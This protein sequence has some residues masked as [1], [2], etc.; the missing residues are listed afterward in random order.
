MRPADDREP[1]PEPRPIAPSVARATLVLL[2]ALNF[3]NYVDRYVL[4]AVLEKIKLDPAFAGV[5]DAQLG[6][7][8]TAF[9][10]VYMIASP[11]SGALGHRV[12][13]KYLVTV[14]VGLWSL[15]TVAS[16]L[17]RNYHE[18]ALAR[19]M[20][21][22]G[23]AGYAT[24]APA[25]L[26]DLY[27]RDRRARVLSIFYIATPVGSALG[28]VIGG[29]VA[30]AS[31]W[32]HAFYV[33][34]GPGLALALLALLM[35]EPTRGAQDAPTEPAGR[36]ARSFGREVLALAENRAFLRVSAATTLMTFSVGGLAFWMPTYFQE[37]RHL[38][39]GPANLYFGGIAV[40]SGIIGTFAGGFLGE[41]WA[42]R[43]PRGLLLLSG[44]GLVASAPFA[45][46]A[47]FAPGLGACLLLGF[48]AQLFVF[49][50][51]GPLNTELV[52]A[53]P[54]EVREVAVGLNVLV[55]HLLGDAISPPLLGKLATVLE[56]AGSPRELALGGAVAAT[57]VP[58]LFAGLVLL[59]P[60][61]ER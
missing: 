47:P 7:L 21:G 61:R 3:L 52:N 50:N 43:N 40:V 45:F 27:A 15:A 41:A 19:A 29:A 24:V 26:S 31:T 54:P 59:V 44:T 1:P 20:I 57:S 35:P 22:F 34:G 30:D 10:V 56:A 5:S 60:G 39:A 46:A 4:A 18:L 33:A 11:A 6:L 36:R 53:A 14:G 2:T 25:I 13:R 38:A 12:P 51:T 17:A 8:Q 9:L 58:L 37:V 32:R 55:I 42:R 48:I 49:L 23:E 16:G 28:F